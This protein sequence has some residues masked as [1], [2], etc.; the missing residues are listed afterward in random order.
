[1]DLRCDPQEELRAAA[2]CAFDRSRGTAPLCQVEIEELDRVGATDL[3][4]LLLADDPTGVV[5]GGGVFHLLERIICRKVDLV[6]TEHIERAAECR[7]VEIPARGDVE[8]IAEVVPEWP[9]AT[10]FAARKAHARIDAPEAEGNIL[11]EVA[12][13]DA[14]IREIIEEPRAAQPQRMNRCF[15]RKT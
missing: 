2:E 1:M 15:H 5:P 8:V 4:P 3:A 6:F 12:D 9:L 11:A 13:A 10:I 14:Q 7:V